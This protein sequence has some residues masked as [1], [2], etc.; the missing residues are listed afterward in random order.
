[1]GAGR[2]SKYKTEY[3]EQAYKLCL[4]GLTDREMAEFFEVNEDTVNEWKKVHPEF[5]ESLKSGKD[6]ADANVAERLYQRAMGYEHNDIE[7]KVVALGNNM[8][9]EVQE[10]PVRKYY[11]PDTG[12]AMA[13]LKNRRKQNWRDKQDYEIGIKYVVFGDEEKLED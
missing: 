7:L 6:V 10:I 4:L 2:P 13:W 9:S 3:A 11:P 8:G 5:S 1:M 12:A